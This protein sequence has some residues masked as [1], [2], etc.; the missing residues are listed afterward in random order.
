LRALGRAVDALDDRAEPVARVVAFRPRL[1]LA[2]QGRFDASADLGD[3]VAVLEPLG[4][5]VHDLADALVVLGKDVLAL[6]LAHFLEDDLLGRLRC[7]PSEDVGGLGELDLH[8]HFGLFAIQLLGLAQGYLERRIVHGVDDLL[9]CEEID[10]TGLG[11]EAGLQVLVRLVGFAGCG[12]HRVLDRRDDHRR[13]DVLLL[14]DRVNQL[15]QRTHHCLNFLAIQLSKIRPR[16][17]PV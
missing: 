6:G 12:Q 15:L 11:I 17:A 7:D 8:V 2:R 10:L 4:R 13:F 1:L 16:A 5:G 3:H 9:H 14:G